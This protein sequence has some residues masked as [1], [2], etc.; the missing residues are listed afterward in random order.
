LANGLTVAAASVVIFILTIAAIGSGPG[1][2]NAWGPGE[3]VLSLSIIVAAV[4]LAVETHRYATLW[5]VYAIESSKFLLYL[6]RVCIFISIVFAVMAITIM[7]IPE[8]LA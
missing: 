7:A 6:K 4:G 8:P 2:K 3:I 1:S 5:G